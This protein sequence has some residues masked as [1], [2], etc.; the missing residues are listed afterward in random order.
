MGFDKGEKKAIMLFEDHIEAFSEFLGPWRRK[1]GERGIGCYFENYSKYSWTKITYVTKKKLLSNTYYLDFTFV[2]DDV[3]MNS[4]WEAKLVY[5]GNLTMKGARLK[6]LKGDD[7]VVNELN[8][9]VN[10]TA[11]LL[12]Y[13]KAVDIF[14]MN[15]K[16]MAHAKQLKITLTPY[17]GGYLW[18]KFPP[19]F[20]PM[21]FSS[22]EVY[23]I[24]KLLNILGTYF[25][26]R[27]VSDEKHEE[28]VV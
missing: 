7:T 19:V 6:V 5:T 20:Y 14:N 4:D 1:N 13:S 3:K 9:N 16:Y 15:F 28:R 17:N 12:K 23:A 10:L 24:C 11:D 26:K 18:I 25:A 8:Q 2:M 27:Y 22:T 21:R